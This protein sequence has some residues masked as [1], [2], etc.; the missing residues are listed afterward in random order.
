MKKTITVKFR[1]TSADFEFDIPN[2]CPHC[3]NTMSP[4]I[5][6]AKSIQR[7]HETYSNIGLFC[8][9]TYD[10]CSKYYCLEYSTYFGER[11]DGY[12][13]QQYRPPKFI[14]YSYKPPIRVDLPENIDKVSSNFVEIYSQAIM[15]EHE[16]LNQIAGVGYRKSAEFLIKDYAISKSPEKEEHI[17]KLMLMKVINDYLDDFPKIQSLSKAVAWI[18][19]DETHYERRHTD[20]DIDDL[21]RFIKATA[22]FIAA[23]FDADEAINFTS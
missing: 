20:K 3:G 15:A 6:S 17:K 19:N 16:K 18:G 1:D 13:G 7:Y 14:E 8:H 2:S 10:D 5:Y 11:T 23:D 12:A 4:N 21:K 9:C 22:Q